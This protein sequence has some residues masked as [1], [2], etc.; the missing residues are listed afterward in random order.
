MLYDASYQAA[1]DFL[2]VYDA[3]AEPLVRGQD[4]TWLLVVAAAVATFLLR[5]YMPSRPEWM[6][7]PA[8]I[9]AV[10]AFTTLAGG[11]WVAARYSQVIG[12]RNHLNRGDYVLVEGRVENFVR[13]DRGGH[14]DESW[15]VRSGGR[16]HT[17]RYSWATMVPG[18]HGSAGPIREGLH[19]RLADVD[20]HIARLEIRK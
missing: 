2:L 6:D 8:V 9:V 5:R 17:Y 15:S 14:R 13:G 10:V 1:T 3:R 20:G 16:L 4:F 19:V 18:F 11:G 7:R 12:L